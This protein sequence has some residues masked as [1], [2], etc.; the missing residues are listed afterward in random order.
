MREFTNEVVIVTGAGA[1]IGRASALA[2]AQ[3]GAKVAVVDVDAKGGNDTVAQISHEGGT[4]LFIEADVSIAP[5]VAEMVQRVAQVYGKL[6]YAFN[7]AGI[8]GEIARIAD[9]NEDDWDR[10]LRVNLKSVWLC[11]KYE[12][13][14][15]VMQG[16]GAIINS[17]SVYGL[18][19][20]ERGMSAYAA[21]KHAIIGLTK[22]AALEYAAAGIRVNALAAGAVETPFRTRLLEKCGDTCQT[23]CRYPIGRT[24]DP[25]EIADAVVW[26]C[27]DRA[28]FITGTTLTADGGLTAR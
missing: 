8:E 28:S 24:A 17:S 13:P 18:V 16:H 25:S 11:M 22:T 6:D 21:S 10:V 9:S 4:A 27:S 26:L 15:M 3:A 19:G 14:L 7:N 12:L 1:G 23:P 2:F 20:S 5:Q